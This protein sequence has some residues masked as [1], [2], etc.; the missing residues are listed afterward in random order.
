MITRKVDKNDALA[1][2]TYGWVK[3]IGANLEHLLVVSWQKSERG[4]LPK[5][6]ELISL[7]QNKMFKSFALVYQVFRL[8]PKVDGLF[9]HMNPEYTILA[10]P[11]AKL[12]GKRVVSWYTHRKVS[13]KVRLLEKIADTILTASKESFRL[14]SKKVKVI[15]HGIDL[16]RFFPI[17]TVHNVSIHRI[18]SIGRISPTKDYES[19]I[20]AVEILKRQ[21]VNVVLDIVGDVGLK[22]QNSYFISLK[23]MVE[24]MGLSENVNFIGSVPN[25]RIRQNCFWKSQIFLNLSNTGSLDKAV[26]EAMA[27][28]IIVLTSNEAFR[29]ILLP[30]LIVKKNDPNQ[31]AEKIK[32]AIGLSENEEAALRKKME[33][34]VEQNHNL[35]NLAEKIIEQF[36]S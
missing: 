30:E 28:G 3:K 6:I 4:D 16:R 32:W 21:G 33:Q 2:F 13:W 14:P 31:L 22:K 1:G 34:E 9:C 29:D 23:Q 25:N 11:V 5:N 10:G 26:L 18:L 20:K 36:G 24:K 35:D 15:G 19:M 17:G 12:F 8:M 7:P 27:C